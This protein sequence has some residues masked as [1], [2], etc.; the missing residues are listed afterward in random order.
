MIG[1][2]EES[3]DDGSVEVGEIAG[4][5]EEEEEEEGLKS[6]SSRTWYEG[7]SSHTHTH[8]HTHV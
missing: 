2:M 8:T 6:S 3:L 7:F 4:E 5:E 1:A